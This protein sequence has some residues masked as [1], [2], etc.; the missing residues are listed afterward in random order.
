MV[1]AGLFPT[2]SDAVPGAARRARA[3]EAER[4]RAL[5]RAGDVAGARLRLPLRLPRPAAH[6]DRARA[7]RARVRSRPARDGAERRLPRAPDERRVGR[8]AHAVRP[9]RRVRGGRGAVHQGVDHRPE[10]VRRRGDGAEQRPA[11]PLRPHGVPLARA[12]APHLRAAARRDRARLL[13]PAEVAHARLRELRLR[14]H[15]LPARQPR[16]RRHPRRRRAG[17]RAV[18]DRAPRLRVRA[19][20]GSWSRSCARRSR[21]RCSTSRSR[22]RSARA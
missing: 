5:L 19:R 12:R 1:F 10:G 15:R 6:G 9:A 17:R 7:A 3:A 18:A 16:A 14:H 4:R 22:L 11:R 20:G 8:G 13:R 21:G 2:D